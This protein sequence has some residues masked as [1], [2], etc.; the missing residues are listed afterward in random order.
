[1]SNKK[2]TTPQKN[3]VEK[4]VSTVLGSFFHFNFIFIFMFEI[5]LNFL[6]YSFEI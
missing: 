5:I 4:S 3:M 2:F 6:L 1:M